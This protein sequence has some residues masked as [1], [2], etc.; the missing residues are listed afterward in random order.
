MIEPM[1]GGKP[2]WTV[3]IPTLNRPDMLK[4]AIE[5]CLAQS[6]PCEIVVIDDHS[7]DE[8]V[9]VAAQFPQIVYIRN[10]RNLGH[11]ASVNRGIECASGSWVKHID[12]D[13]FLHKDCLLR[14]SAAIMEAQ[15]RR[16]DPRMITCVAINIDVAGRPLG[17]TRTLPVDRAALMKR[18]DLL[19]M[20]MCDQVPLG[21]PVQVAHERR[22]ALAVGGWNAAR[23]ITFRNGDESEFWIRLASQGDAIFLPEA[24]GYRTLWSG[25]ETPSCT[26]RRQISRYL[27]QRISEQ[28]SDDGIG[29]IPQDIARYLDLHWGL[30]ALKNGEPRAGLRFL[31]GGMFHWSAYRYIWRRSR[32]ADAIKLVYVCD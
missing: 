2:T 11:S 3:I 15:Q 5:S 8:T 14:M 10:A 32:F 19:P 25:N 30:V 13:D 29:Q 4:R 24:L 21:T 16:H 26:D 31:L 17:K 27:K 7:S 1:P 6:E 20:M 9:Q 12:D 28:M 23:P 18:K 22:A